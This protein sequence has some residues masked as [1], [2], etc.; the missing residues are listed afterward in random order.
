MPRQL[1]LPLPPRK[2]CRKCGGTGIV[3][4]SVKYRGQ[5]VSTADRCPA[6]R[7]WRKRGVR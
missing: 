2:P 6:C 4:Q 1:A 3:L 7:P 5:L